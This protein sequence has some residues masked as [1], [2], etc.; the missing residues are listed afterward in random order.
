MAQVIA[1]FDKALYLVRDPRDLAV[2]LSHFAFTPY[3]LGFYPHRYPDQETFLAQTLLRRGWGWLSH[4]EQYLRLSMRAKVHVVFYERLAGDFHAELARLLRYLEI[5]FDAAL[6]DQIAAATSV[7]SMRARDSYHVR[8]GKAGGWANALTDQQKRWF[9]IGLG[10]FLR[11]L[12]YPVSD[13]ELANGTLPDL[14]KPGR[15]NDLRK[16]AR[17]CRVRMLIS[18]LLI[19]EIRESLP[20]AAA[21][22]FGTPVLRSKSTDQQTN[23][24]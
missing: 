6:L 8:E 19:S 7:K 23:D 11:M 22:L 13:T 20:S 18:S 15:E 5:E 10:P 21:E 24:E 17:A 14:P 4:V 3:Y 9:R 12:N 1:S 16:A 2:S